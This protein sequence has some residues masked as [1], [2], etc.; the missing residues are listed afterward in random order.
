M[1]NLLA[2]PR[3]PGSFSR[4]GKIEME[5]E[6]WLY[7]FQTK[8]GKENSLLIPSHAFQPHSSGQLFLVFFPF[9]EAVSLEESHRTNMLM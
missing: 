1:K 4:N 2:A 8:N 7:V 3:T 9:L 6:Y 5:A